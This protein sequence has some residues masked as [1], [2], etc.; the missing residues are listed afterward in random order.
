MKPLA[1]FALLTIVFLWAFIYIRIAVELIKVKRCN[2]YRM[3]AAW[4]GSGGT[5]LALY[6]TGTHTTVVITMYYF[7]TLFAFG[8]A[9]F[10]NHLFLT[11]LP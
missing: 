4:I 9:V 11:K 2:L 5:A 7:I 6:Y 1:I 10:L 8:T 3:L